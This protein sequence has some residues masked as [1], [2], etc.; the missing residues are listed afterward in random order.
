MT[1]ERENVFDHEKLKAASDLRVR[2]A[3]E[4]RRSK[5]AWAASVQL[6]KDAANL[7]KE[8]ILSSKIKGERATTKR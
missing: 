7:E 1:P 3:Q 2:A 4:R 5:E 8:A 6:D